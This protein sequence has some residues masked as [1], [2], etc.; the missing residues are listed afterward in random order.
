MGQVRHSTSAS[1]FIKQSPPSRNSICRE[2]Q[3]IWTIKSH[4]LSPDIS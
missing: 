1:P 2:G 3:L 4:Q